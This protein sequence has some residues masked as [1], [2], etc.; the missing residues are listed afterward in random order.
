MQ[1]TADHSYKALMNYYSDSSEWKWLF[2]NAVDWD[3]LL[4][5]YEPSFPTSEGFQNK[6]ELLSFYED[7]L[8][9]T[10]KWCSEVLA[11][12]ARELD[13]V[14]GGTAV[15][16][17]V[18]LS[19]P[20][21]KTISEMREM[22]IIGLCVEKK[23][24]GLGAPILVGLVLFEQICRA[25]ISTSTQ[26]GFFTCIA[27]M[28]HRYCPED[29]KSEL[30]PKIIKGE[31]S[32]SMCMTEPDSGSD[33]GSLRT[34]AEKQPDGTYRLNGTKC[35]ITNGGGGLGFVLA[36]V[37]GAPKG[38][39]GISMFFLR[40][41]IEEPGTNKKKHNYRITKIEDKMGM[42]GSNTC[43]VVY[44]DSIGQLIGEENEGFKLMLHLMNE[45]RISVGLQ[46]MGGMEAAIGAA[47][48]YAA[49][50]KQFGKPINELPL[51]KR[52]IKDWETER[53]A[54]RVLI[55]DTVLHFDI[56][57][58]LETKKLHTG[59]LNETEA[60]LMKKSGRIVRKRTP[61]VKYYGAEAYANLSQ[62]AIQAYGGY[63][64]M[65]D[66]DVERYHRD[67]FGAL[68]YEGTSQIQA[69]MA[70]K[71]FVKNVTKKPG[72]F[73]TSLFTSHPIGVM[74]SGTET[75]L[76]L[77]TVEYAF[78]KNVAGLLMRCLKPELNTG[79]KGFLEALSQLN[80]V[81]KKEYWE[82][83]DRYDK[84]ME[85]AE[86]LCQALSYLETLKLLAKHA[87]RDDSR[88]DLYFRYLK[89]INPRLSGIYT[90][91]AS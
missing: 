12:R 8:T 83:A 17:S 32:G 37:K 6:D 91:W 15:D 88:K 78:Q 31:I 18:Q 74:M 87:N 11:P 4:S 61:L 76:S 9:T 70:M 80:Q 79:E 29:L 64:F 49:T 53:D 75:D 5:L 14:G 1:I 35:F 33:V 3:T 55:L 26:V 73:V 19:G 36:R 20:L 40:E 65:R 68:L 89:L 60:K 34:T 42:N 7:L 69:L 58:Y 21:L 82:Q 59:D 30:L 27:D 90:E 67:S 77:A 56:L 84:L 16:G 52:N 62:K 41:W 13:L 23:Y 45:A 66:Y 54:F 25:C 72:K 22:D 86:T 57:Q 43:E 71:D 63:G 46:G 2:K 38:L 50:R 47:T 81:F 44:E 51:M 10:G 85:N 39:A 28:I 24:G 48:D